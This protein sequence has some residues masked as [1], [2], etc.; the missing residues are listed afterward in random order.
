[1]E[2]NYDELV[3]YYNTRNYQGAIDYLNSFEFEGKDAVMVRRELSKLERNKAIDES[4]RRNLIGE[5]A[6]AFNFMDGLNTNYV[7]RTRNG[8]YA[9]GTTFKTKNAYGDKY[10]DYINNLRTKDGNLVNAI[11]IEIDNKDALTQLQSELGITDLR[12][13]DLGFKLSAGSDGKYNLNIGVNNTNLYKVYNAVCKLNKADA[14][15]Y[16]GIGAGIG[17]TASGIAGFFSMGL[18]WLGT[19]V[20]T[21][22]GAALGYGIAHR[23][24]DLHIKA[25]ANGK[26][27]D[28]SEFD[29]D[30]LRDAIGVV[31]EAKE[32]YDEIQN[33]TLNVDTYSELSVSGFK[34]AAHAKAFNDRMAGRY[35][36][37]QFEDMNKQLDDMMINLIAGGS[38]A[39]KKVYAYGNNEGDVEDGEIKKGITLEEIKNTDSENVKNEILLAMN[40]KRCTYSM[41]T[42]DG[43]IGT[44]FTITADEDKGNNISDKYGNRRLEVF[45]EGFTMG[46]AEA[47]YESDTKTKS[48]R[49]NAD[50]KKLGYAMTLSNNRKIGYEN[51]IPYEEVYNKNTKKFE[52]TQISEEEALQSLNESAII[53]RS[54][55]Y[56]LQNYNSDTGNVEIEDTEGYK[57]YSLQEILNTVTE[58]SLNELYPKGAYS[59]KER[60]MKKVLFYSALIQNLN[61]GM[62]NKVKNSITD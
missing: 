60:D 21:G 40:D 58:N 5:D 44:L 11:S 26:T 14:G 34:S 56:I 46:D 55:D 24:N 32:K 36:S 3:K 42:K 16:A 45:V 4:M 23:I 15:V 38:F 25:I 54:I 31:N 29:Y 43:A 22:M 28:D 50:M 57:S 13:N 8:T 52:R 39:D 37:S 7:D 12:N 6:E 59:K 53:D 49:D 19:T 17:A 35:N 2:Y 9:D 61:K 1:M 41:A 10:I 51:G 30:N 62:R 18:G 20:T 48:A 47:Y 33:R 27:Y